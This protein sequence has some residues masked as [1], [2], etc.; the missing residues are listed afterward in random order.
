[1]HNIV[2]ARTFCTLQAFLAA[3]GRGGAMLSQFVNG[4]LIEV[5]VGALLLS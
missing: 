2:N 4:W 5:N 3:A 1:M